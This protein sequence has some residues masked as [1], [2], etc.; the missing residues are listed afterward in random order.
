MMLR[1][2]T[3]YVVVSLALAGLSLNA[4]AQGLQLVSVTSVN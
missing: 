4:R 1:S 3:P 2:T